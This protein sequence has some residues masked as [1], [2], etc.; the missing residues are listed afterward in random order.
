MN[1]MNGSAVSPRIASLMAAKAAKLNVIDLMVLEFFGQHAYQ[2]EGRAVASLAQWEICKALKLSKD[3]AKG[4]FTRLEGAGALA[5]RQ[6]NKEK[7]EV[8]MTEIC[9]LGL[10]VLGMTD[11]LGMPA[12]MPRDL[13]RLLTGRTSAFSLAVIEAWKAKTPL[14][15]GAREAWSGLDRDLQAIEDMLRI[16][17]IDEASAVIEALHAQ[18]QTDLEESQGVYTFET[19]DGLVQF[20]Q[21]AFQA[22]KE[23]V[24]GVDLAFARNVTNRLLKLRPEMVTKRSITKLVAEIGYSRLLGF[25]SRHDAASA[26][27][28][29]AAT[30]ARGGWSTPKGIRPKF[31]EVAQHALVTYPQGGEFPT[32]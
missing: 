28:V 8:A 25:V 9:Q 6:E 30:V 13:R 26:E 32:A 15:Q 24:A 16:R 1:L 3:Q 17:A 7:G 23:A 20:D 27:R 31:Y 29:L 12:D 18:A 11:A 5:R 14:A 19:S 21:K 4:S 10:D 2:Q 22:E